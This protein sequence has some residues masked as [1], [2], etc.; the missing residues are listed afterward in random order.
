MKSSLKTL[1]KIQKFAIDEQRKKLVA[2]QNQEDLL[3]IKLNKLIEEF[4]REKEFS[5]NN[6]DFNFGAYLERYLKEKEALEKQIEQ[7]R[8]QIEELRDIIRDLFKEQKTYDIVDEN[9]EKA[10][11]AEENAKDRQ[12]LDEIGTNAFIKRNS[13]K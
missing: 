11:A 5:K 12:Q 4:E 1:S 13:K 2:L 7:I 8:A 6:E 3:L 9:R 10:V